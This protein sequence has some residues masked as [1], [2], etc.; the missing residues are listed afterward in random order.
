MANELR[1][2]ADQES[3]G[4]GGVYR[5]SPGSVRRA[6][7]AGWSREDV[8]TWIEQHSRTGVPQPLAYLVDD[9]ARRHGNTVCIH[10]RKAINGRSADGVTN[11]FIGAKVGDEHIAGGIKGRA[12]W[13]RPY[14]PL[15]YKAARCG[16]HLHSVVA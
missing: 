13:V 3:R 16:E 10:L 5:F 9:V 8:Q 2:L 1:L 12:S 4:G 6:F 14:G 11:N 15:V 7:N